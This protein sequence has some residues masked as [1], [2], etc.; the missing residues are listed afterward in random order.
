M[1]TNFIL[2]VLCVCI[3]SNCTSI[4]NTT[5][6][7]PF[8]GIIESETAYL[9]TRFDVNSVVYKE[10]EKGS[11]VY[12]SSKIKDFYMVYLIDP[13]TV[14]YQ[15]AQKHKYYLHKPVF[16][17]I[18]QSYTLGKASIIDRPFDKSRKYIVGDRGGCYY[19]N[20]K[21][22]RVYVDRSICGLK[23]IIETID[24]SPRTK[25]IYRP[26]PS[27]KCNTVQCRGTTKKGS[28]C[29]NRTTNCSGRCHLHH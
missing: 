5:Y 22:N 6:S 20:S 14:P 21:G 29:K 9:Y 24:P 2:L 18:T 11:I 13:N 25:R 3:L 23:P 15:E 17:R 16:Q 28:R 10:V 26:S 19:I 27:R 1:K 4:Q 8:W 7:G 12:F